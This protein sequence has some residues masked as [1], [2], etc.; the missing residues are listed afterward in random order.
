MEKELFNEV[1]KLLSLKRTEFIVNT[2]LEDS[3]CDP[4]S[5]PGIIRC[6]LKKPEDAIHEGTHAFF[7][8]RSIMLREELGEDI[9]KS[10][11]NNIMTDNNLE[12]TTSRL[13]EVNS[14]NITLDICSED[15]QK[16]VRFKSET[17]KW[18]SP[19][20]ENIELEKKITRLYLSI[21]D[22]DCICPKDIEFYNEVKKDIDPMIIYN[23]LA[24]YIGTY[25]LI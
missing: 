13:I 19:H 16:T 22:F 3:F 18:I 14:Q 24:R 17:T 23:K 12:E 4:C 21:Y 8:E 25:E 1:R 2:D 9:Y 5:E 10:K 11:I 15:I 6:Y 20:Y 7:E